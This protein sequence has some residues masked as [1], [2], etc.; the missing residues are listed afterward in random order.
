MMIVNM[1]IPLEKSFA[2]H[3]KSK[4]WSKINTIKPEEIYISSNKKRWFDCHKC[5]H[6]FEKSL[7][8]V[9]KDSWCPYCTNQKLCNN[10]NCKDCFEKSFASHHKNVYWSDK[11]TL[12]PRNVFKYSTKKMWFNCNNCNHTFKKIL[13][14]ISLENSWCPYCCKN[15]IVLCE[16]EEC[17]QCFEK[18]FASNKRSKFWS[19][20]NK[21]QPRQVFN[22]SSKKFLFNCDSCLHIYETRLDCVNSWCQYCSN[23]KLCE[24]EDCKDCFNKSFASNK[25]SIFWS[26]K[27]EIK[28]RQ[29]LKK[30]GRKFIFNC[31]KC[32]NEFESVIKNIN[33]NNTWCPYCKN[34]TELKLLNWLKQKQ[35]KIKGQVIFDWAKNKKYDFLLEDYNL[36]I[37]LDGRQHFQQVSNWRPPEYN[38]K[39]DE[40]KNKLALEN[41][42][43]II[44]ICQEIVFYEKEDWENKLLNMINKVTHSNVISINKIGSVYE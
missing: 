6:S 22:R 26:D 10:T 8:H 19:D 41:G 43:R 21:L 5:S 2:S 16:N 7:H 3:P 37:E 11:N 38:K 25:R 32:K 29:I 12:Q 31:D 40:L 33:N 34:K 17:K 15:S 20:K 24:N 13:A 23:K 18:S 35:L 27:N 28:P 42:Y 9:L 36:I 1:V 4:F 39:N 14:H 44:R 30:S